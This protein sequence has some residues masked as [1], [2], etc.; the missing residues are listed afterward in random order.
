MSKLSADE[1][2]PLRFDE[3]ARKLPKYA[4]FIENEQL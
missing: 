2:M 1:E 3:Q 4:Q